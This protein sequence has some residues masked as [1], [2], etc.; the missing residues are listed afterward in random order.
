MTV[1]RQ[2]FHSSWT[3]NL[4]EIHSWYKIQSSTIEQFFMPIDNSLYAVLDL[5]SN[6]FHLLIARKDQNQLNYIDR[7]KDSIRLGSYLTEEETITEDGIQ[8]ALSSLQIMA[9]RLRGIPR[10][11]IRVIGT[12]TLRA[13]SN[14]ESFLPAAEKIIGSPIDIITGDEEARL[15]WQGVSR[16][17]PNDDKKRLVFDIGGGSTEFIVGNNNTMHRRSV[18]MGCVSFSRRYFPDQSVTAKKYRHALAAARSEMQSLARSFNSSQWAEAIGASG[19]I[20]Y[21]Q[22][23]LTQNQQG[24]HT[25]TMEGLNWL[26]RQLI[27]AEH[28]DKLTLAGIEKDRA[29]V[30]PGGLSILQGICMELD[31]KEL[32]VSEYSLK[33]GVIIEL[34]GYKSSDETHGQTIDYLLKKYRLDKQQA[35]RV[36]KL[37]MAFFRKLADSSASGDSQTNG[38]SHPDTTPNGE[39]LLRWASQLH[40]IGLSVGY[41]G[42]HKHSAYLVEYTD[43]PGFSRSEQKMLSFLLLNHRRKLRTL[44]AS[45]GFKPDWNLVLV[46][47]LACLFNRRRVNFEL[48]EIMLAPDKN[49][50]LLALPSIWL[51][52][53][54]LTE[55]DLNQ[56]S[57][58]WKKQGFELNI[59]A[60]E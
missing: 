14:A 52:D 2:G 1:I 30:F 4:H 24:A 34:A 49:G 32:N 43:M 8:R 60:L 56:E 19:T 5:G 33:E 13:A 25:I 38:S 41:A 26:S 7:V 12:N 28:P 37:A 3:C 22:R 10:G 15:I 20:R 35:D 50:W 59:S 46:L 58:Y 9:E 51:T 29:T 42:Y 36:E 55:E 48:P 17:F 44:E 40:E 11:N 18:Y 16:D 27:A 47:R 45:Y 54:P 6:S 53:H 31:I 39:K 23:L 21:I 57:T